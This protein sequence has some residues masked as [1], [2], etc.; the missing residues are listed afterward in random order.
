MDSLTWIIIIAFGLDLAIG[1]PRYAF[2]PVRLIGNGLITP[3]ERILRHAG[4]GSRKGGL[5]LILGTLGVSVGSV[6]LISG[7]LSVFPLAGSLFTLYLIYACLAVKDLRVHVELVNQALGAGDL[8]LARSRLAMI[9][10]RETGRLDEEG[11][12]RACVET[13]AENL[14]DGIIA[15]LFY[16]FLGGAPMMIL[17]K[18][19]NTMDSM[20]GYKSE[21][22]REFG[23]FPAKLDDLFNW[24][25]ARLSLILIMLAGLNPSRR[26]FQAWGVALRNR[27]NHASPNAGY[28]E[29][30]MAAL[31]NLRLGGP[32]HYHGQIIEKPAINAAGRRVVA[33]DINR[34][35]G[36]AFR[37]ALLALVFLIVIRNLV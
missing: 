16:A 7:I 15:P 30:A 22:Y 20:V 6:M 21:Q 33:S 34:V 23:F 32:N 28:P 8:P 9:V 10:G 36:L 24:L 19:V 31:L 12:A 29:A 5:L 25:P 14:S 37:S 11:I 26:W 27:R 2:H 18:A 13:V 4:L 1:D 3:L 17:Y 35:L